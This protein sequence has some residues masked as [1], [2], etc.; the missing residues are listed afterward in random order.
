M[1]NSYRN[2]YGP[3][4]DQND[5]DAKIQEERQKEIGFSF[6]SKNLTTK[7]FTQLVI[8]ASSYCILP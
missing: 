7:N 6:D 4:D 8:G 5:F 1:Q 3:I 2:F